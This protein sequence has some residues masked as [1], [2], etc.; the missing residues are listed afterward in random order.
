MKAKRRHKFDEEADVSRISA[1]HNDLLIQILSFVSTKDAVAT[2][3]LSKRWRS[4]WTMVPKLEYDDEI[5]QGT[6]LSRLLVDDE[7]ESVWKF[8]EKLLELHKAPLLETLRIRLG[9]KRPYDDNGH[10]VEKLVANAVDR[11]V[12]EIYLV[13][14]WT[15]KLTSLPKSFYNCKTLVE[16][17]LSNK[18]LVDVPSSACLPS[19][20]RL[21][22]FFVVYKDKDSLVKLLSSCPVLDRSKVFLGITDRWRNPRPKGDVFRYDPIKVVVLGHAHEDFLN[23]IS[24]ATTLSLPLKDPKVPLLI[25]IS[26]FLSRS[27]LLV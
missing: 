25:S 13:L 22:L 8:L 16:L 17:T 12:R 26:L 18:I 10:V 21:R 20:K 3:F 14:L 5:S 19:L 4:L 24:L 27:C 11:L 15:T 1:L 9:Q 23:S 7:C 6:Y 2:T